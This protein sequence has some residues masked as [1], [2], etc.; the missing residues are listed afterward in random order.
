VARTPAAEPDATLRIGARG[1]GEARRV[2]RSFLF[3]E[4]LVAIDR[5]GR[6]TPRIA[7]DWAWQD[8]GRTLRVNIRPDV[9]FHDDTPLTAALAV[10]IIRQQI[11]KEDTLG[12]EAVDSV[13]ATDQRTIVFHLS[14]PDGF[15]PAAL[16]GLLMVDDRKPNIGTGPFR[17]VPNTTGLEAVRNP[18]YYRGLPGISR[19]Q[20]VPYATPRAA[21]VGLMRG[22]VNMALE[23]NKESVEFLEGAARFQILPSIQPFYVPLVFNVRNPIL[24]RVE[25]RR[26]ISDAIDREEI[27][28]QG[29]RGRGQRADANDPVWPFHWAYNRSPQSQPFNPNAARVR[30]DAAGLPMRPAAAGRRASRVEFNCI[31][32]NEE[33]LYE[34]IGLLLQRQ[35]AAVGIDLVLEGLKGD[36]MVA[37]LGKGDF[38]SY[39]FQLTSGRDAGWTYR[40]WH[41]PNGALGPVMQNTGYSGA[42]AVLDRLRQARDEDDDQ[43]RAAIGDLRQRFYDDVPAVFIA[44]TQLTRAV[45]KRFDVGDPSDPD[46]FGNMWRWQVASTKTASR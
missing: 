41:S 18:S 38:D 22:D 14:R 23:I 7:T 31:F 17:L 19:I 10:E 12:L 13:E 9:R 36:E 24:A 39:L 33:P 32:F 30:L 15:L 29:M 3:A 43:I 35:L 27:V 42:D 11:P 4:G 6:P 46:I 16:A 1:S 5:Q 28:S 2:L 40:F 21:W 34:R 20:F 26:A 37:R 45:D 25:V 8:R 44:W